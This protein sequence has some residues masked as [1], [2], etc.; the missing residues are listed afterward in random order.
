MVA[1]QRH[2]EVGSDRASPRADRHRNDEVAAGDEADDI[3]LALRFDRA[4][5][6]PSYQSV[7]QEVERLGGKPDD[8][9]AAIG[10][11]ISVEAFEVSD[12]VSQQLAQASRAKDVVVQR[13][14]FYTEGSIRR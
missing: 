5:T 9:V 6:Q 3:T 1:A 13:P 4:V 2:D 8:W 10:P 12:D 7:R 11:H 14:P